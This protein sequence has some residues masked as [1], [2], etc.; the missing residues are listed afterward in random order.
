MVLSDKG[1]EE[2]NGCTEIDSNTWDRIISQ[3]K[4]AAPKVEHEERTSSVL[5]NSLAKGDVDATT[6]GRGAR[7][8]FVISKSNKLSLPQFYMLLD[9]DLDKTIAKNFLE[10]LVNHHKLVE[11]CFSIDVLELAY[12]K[13]LYVFRDCLEVDHALAPEAFGCDVLTYFAFE[14]H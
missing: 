6:K 13:L 10:C 4:Q 12:L 9:H 3:F 5:S 1:S 14:V 8:K 11:Q 7:T 2:G